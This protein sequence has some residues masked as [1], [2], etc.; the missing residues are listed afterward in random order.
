MKKLAGLAVL[1][2]IL[3]GGCSL[4][5]KN[6]IKICTNHPEIASYIEMF[7]ASQSE[8]YA[9]VAYSDSPIDCLG[10]SNSPDVI[11][12]EYLNSGE[13]ISHFRSLDPLF[14]IKALSIPAFYPSLL[15][16]GIHNS[17]HTLLP[18]S[19][20][21]PAVMYDPARVGKIESFSLDLDTIGSISFNFN[22]KEKDAIRAIG[23]SPRWFPGF[24]YITAR[25]KGTRFREGE[26][27]RPVW[28]RENLAETITYINNWSADING[29]REVENSF[30]DKYFHAP[31]YSL[32]SEGRIGFAYT[33]TSSFFLIPGEKRKNLNIK[34]L[35][36][37][38]DIPILE[39]I[40][41]TGIAA[42]SRNHK[43][44]EKFIAWLYQP[45]TQE[46]ILEKNRFLR[47]RS[48]GV[49]NGFSSIK[50]VNREIFPLYYPDLLG[51]IPPADII[52]APPVLPARWETLKTDVVIPIIN[53][54]LLLEDEASDDKIKTIM[55]EAV[56]SWL[57]QNNGGIP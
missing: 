10:G 14:E 23:F 54:V 4:V 34:W 6:S 28:N 46:R 56:G 18:L 53:D 7:N 9:E 24:L 55:A 41:F 51:K 30:R 8:I 40:I 3:F 38:R 32:I 20:D 1:S 33:D 2:L 22:K 5:Q 17:Q 35:S 15:A 31:Y 43:A 36:A 47:I 57:K 27:L 45:S 11:I 48:F 52:K 13:L 37:G 29:S 39:E 49:V 19:F 25:L 26:D 44:A 16:L 42:R 21:L 12:S 50:T